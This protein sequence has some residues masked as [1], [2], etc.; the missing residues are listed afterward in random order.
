[1]TAQTNP[2]AL[3]SALLAGFQEAFESQPSIN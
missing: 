1:M 2:G 3:D